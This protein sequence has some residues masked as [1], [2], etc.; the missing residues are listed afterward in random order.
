[1]TLHNKKI[2]IAGAGIGGLAAAACLQKAGFNVELFER[3]GELRTAG[4][5]LS[6]MANALTALAEMGVTPDFKEAREFESLRFLTQDGRPIRNIQFGALTRRIGQPNPAIHRATLQQA[7][8]EQAAGCKI[9]LGVKATGYVHDRNGVIV[10]LSDG[11]EIVADVLIGADGFNSNIRACMVGQER[12]NDWRYIIWRATL[13]FTHPNVTPGYVAHY[14]GRGQRFGL[15]DIGGGNVYWWGT[16][17]MSAA[18]ARQWQ[19]GKAEIQKLYADWADEVQDVIASTPEEGISAMSAQDKSFLENWGDGPVTLLGDAAH[20]M[21]TSLGQGAGVAIEDAAVLAH[22][23]ATIQDTRTALRT[24]ENRRRE[25]A[26]AMVEGSRSLSHIEQLENPLSTFARRL[27]FRFVPER[28]LAR[29]NEMA[30]VF[31]GVES[32]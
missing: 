9:E 1:M 32:C 10:T 28:S 19:G 16:R 7:L 27:Y 21:L 25:R 4:S 30:L 14:W 15:A 22:C 6:L 23:L 12:P 8:L 13:P 31:P 26:R 2:V 24:Y 11:R 5:G 29:K 18:L 3:A 17:N 20:P